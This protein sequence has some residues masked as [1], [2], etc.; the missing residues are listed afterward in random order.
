MIDLHEH[1]L[2]VLL[3]EG[4]AR[5]V[6]NADLGSFALDGIEPLH[7]LNQHGGARIA[8]VDEFDGRAACVGPAADVDGSR[9]VARCVLIQPLQARVVS[10]KEMTCED[11]LADPRGERRDTVVDGGYAVGERRDGEVHGLA[12]SA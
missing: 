7:H 8:T 9:A 11:D 5:L 3:A 12:G 2:R 6:I 10:L 4:T 1:W